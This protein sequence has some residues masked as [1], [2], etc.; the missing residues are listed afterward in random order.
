MNM[1]SAVCK[2]REIKSVCGGLYFFDFLGAIKIY[3][4]PCASLIF[5]INAS[6][7]KP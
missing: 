3:S 7:A 2:L 4:F 6:K 1:S 5:F